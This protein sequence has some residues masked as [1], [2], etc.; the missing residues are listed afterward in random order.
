MGGGGA[1]VSGRARFGLPGCGSQIV[2][3][4]IVSGPIVPGPIV[5]GPIVSGPIVPRASHGSG[6]P[7]FGSAL[8]VCREWAERG[9]CSNRGVCTLLHPIVAPAEAPQSAVLAGPCYGP[10]AAVG[11]LRGP[12]HAPAAIAAGASAF[13]PAP[14][15]A[16]ARSAYAKHDSDLFSGGAAAGGAAGAEDGTSGRFAPEALELPGR[17]TERPA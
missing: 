4:P 3:G 2:P 17:E 9:R 13:A 11:G 15:D 12:V 16:Y 10:P 6:A 7:H 5:S 1:P 14:A 8:G